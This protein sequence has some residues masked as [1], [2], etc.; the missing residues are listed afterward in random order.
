M[1][2]ASNEYRLNTTGKPAETIIQR[3]DSVA[4]RI[5]H[6][7]REAMTKGGN[8]TESVIPVLNKVA[9]ALRGKESPKEKGNWATRKVVSLLERG[10]QIQKEKD[11]N[12]AKN[13]QQY[14]NIQ[15]RQPY[16]LEMDANGKLRLKMGG[17]TSATP[18]ELGIREEFQKNGFPGYI[19]ALA[20][21]S[22]SK[23]LAPKETTAANS[24][25]PTRAFGFQAVPA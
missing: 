15:G 22:V 24:A 11:E 4:N 1:V 14:Y 13:N 20:A 19:R 6:N 16:E 9:N 17:Y 12:F 25:P 7:I 3:V 5:G 21:V 2:I 23:M 8:I 18:L 10:N